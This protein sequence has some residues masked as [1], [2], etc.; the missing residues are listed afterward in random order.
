MAA[1]VWSETA[2]VGLLRI[3]LLLMVWLTQPSCKTSHPAPERA[4]TATTAP[5]LLQRDP[6][7]R[8][9]ELDNG[10]TFLSQ[11]VPTTLN[12]VVLGLVVNVG[13]LAERDEER[14]LA[15]FVEHLAFAGT[16]SFPKEE[17]LSFLDRAG[18]VFGADTLGQTDHRFTSYLLELPGDDLVLL[19]RAV[20]LL[21]DWAHGIGFDSSEVE[22]ERSVI[23]AEMRLRNTARGRLQDRQSAGWLRGSRYAERSPLG[24]QAVLQTVS[25]DRLEAFYRRWYHPGNF[26]VVASGAFDA[27]TMQRRV[28]QRFGALATVA[29]PEAVPRVAI[30]ITPGDHFQL[31]ADPEQAVSAVAVGLQRPAVGQRF[32]ADLR[33]RLVDGLIMSALEQRIHALPS[34]AGSALLGASV[35][36]VWGDAGLYDSLQ[37]QGTH[38]DAPENALAPLLAELER[39]ARQGLSP[40]ELERARVALKRARA[41][42]RKKQSSLRSQAAT[43][44]RQHWLGQVVLAPEQEDEVAARLLAAVTVDEVNAAGQRWVRDTARHI[45]VVERDAAHLPPEAALRELAESVRRAPLGELVADVPNQLMASP[46]EPGSVASEQQLDSLDAHVWMLSNGARVVFKRMPSEVGKVSL[47]ASSPGG[48]HGVPTAELASAGASAFMVSQLGLGSH[49]AAVT[50]RL[51]SAAGAQLTPWISDH[52]R[53]VGG[54]AYVEGLETLFQ[55]LHLTLSEPGRDAAG[56]ELGRRRLREAWAARFTDRAAF[57]QKE[58]ERRVWDDN[59]LY[60]AHPPDAVSQLQLEPVRSFYRE[61]FS[62]IGSFTFV[63]VGDTTREALSPLIQRYLASIPSGGQPAS[64][65]PPVATY[66][67][68]VTRVRVERGTGDEQVSVFFHGDERLGPSARYELDALSGY[69][70]IRL[71]EVLRQRLG[72][73]YAVKTWFS[74]R[75]PPRT[76]YEIGFRFECEPG[77]GEGLKRAAFDEIRALQRGGIEEH[78]VTSLRHQRERAAEAELRSAGFWLQELDDLYRREGDAVELLSQIRD[79]SH[80]SSDALRRSARRLLRMSQYVDAVLEPELG[81]HEQVHRGN[82]PR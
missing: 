37:L 7:L 33:K 27:E 51:L 22:R 44:A 71:R 49:D 32:E 53:G 31:E 64:S 8:V 48:L 82:D 57:F 40:D 23:L 55:A 21:A 6:A 9:V 74:L 62:Q 75:Q 65:K 78:Y 69:L 24:D 42:S 67:P 35:H 2:L 54:A 77:Q 79:T 41:E 80:I 14:G 13:S 20:V 63:F 10:V 72:G 73:T 47:R 16:Q 5:A 3:A 68:G 39:L 19:D 60:T 17:L 1:G 50:Q 26:T 28:E 66:R 43:A 56:F 15:H 30:A 34:R 11:V 4:G 76:G 25:A 38:A 29:E 61:R 18:L 36:L 70:E 52:E 58:I 45:L 12:R 46:P 81:Q 59:P